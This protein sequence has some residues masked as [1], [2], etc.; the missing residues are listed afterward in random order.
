MIQQLL[1]EQVTEFLGRT[2][3]QRHGKEMQGYRNGDG[4]AAELTIRSGTVAVHRPRVRDVGERFESRLLP[5]FT[6]APRR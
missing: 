5:L 1:V 4:K 6:D 2:K 3:Y